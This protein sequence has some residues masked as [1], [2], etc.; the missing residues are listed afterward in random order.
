MIEEV[1]PQS[2]QNHQTETES[3][4]LRF[5]GAHLFA[6]VEN[7]ILSLKGNNA[8]QRL[9]PLV[10]KNEKTFVISIQFDAPLFFCCAT[11]SINYF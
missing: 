8:T 5:V 9:M 11:R 7:E 2:Y 3:E 4:L 1:R 10:L 6:A